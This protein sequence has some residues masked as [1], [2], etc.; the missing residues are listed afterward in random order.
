MSDTDPFGATVLPGNQL[1]MAAWNPEVFRKETDEV[2]VCL[3][4]NGRGGQP[5]FQAV[6]VCPVK[7]IGRSP[8]LDMDGQHQIFTVPMVPLRRHCRVRY[9]GG[10]TGSCVRQV[11]GNVIDAA[12]ATS[13]GN[14][15]T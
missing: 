6:P 10:Q 2:V 9:P 8:G 3:A 11:A 13:S 7:R 15:T 12:D 4:I 14:F 1:D 5:D